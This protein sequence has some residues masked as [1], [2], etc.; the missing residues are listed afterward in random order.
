MPGTRAVLPDDATIGGI[1]LGGGGVAYLDLHRPENK[2]PPPMGSLQETLLVYSLV[3]SVVLNV[4]AVER[5]SLLWNGNQ[6]PSLA[7]H[8]D[9]AGP[10]APRPQ[11]GG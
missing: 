2:P 11:L 10:L 8:L 4:P 7:G 5:L 1:Y 3:N 9:N 6:R